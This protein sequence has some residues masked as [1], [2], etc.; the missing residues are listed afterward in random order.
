MSCNLDE[1]S[2]VVECCDVCGYSLSCNESVCLW[3]GAE[4]GL[5]LPCSGGGEGQRRLHR[6]KLSELTFEG[7]LGKGQADKEWEERGGRRE[8]RAFHSERIA[9][10]KAGT[11]PVILAV[12]SGSLKQGFMVIRGSARSWSWSWKGGRIQVLHVAGRVGVQECGLGP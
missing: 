2:R 8:R 7:Y 5:S 9:C 12:T 4:G 3:S 11:P 10:A 1:I 6:G